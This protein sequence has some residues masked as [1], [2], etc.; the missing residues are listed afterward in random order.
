[1]TKYKENDI[2]IDKYSDKRKILGV[3]GEVY[4]ISQENEFEYASSVATKKDLEDIGYKLLKEEFNPK[5]GDEYYYPYVC[6]NSSNKLFWKDD[7]YDIK[8]K[9]T[10][11][12]YRTKEESDAKLKKILDAINNLG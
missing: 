7:E 8:R 2:L 6:Y 10:V 3:C 5:E 11:G 4:F 9:A 1:M 12:V